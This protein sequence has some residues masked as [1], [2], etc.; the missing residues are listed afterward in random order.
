MSIPTS[1]AA[2]TSSMPLGASTSR[3][4]IVNFTVSLAGCVIRAFR[5]LRSAFRVEVRNAASAGLGPRGGRMLCLHRRAATG[6]R[7]GPRNAAR[8]TRHAERGRS[9]WLEGALA[10][11]NVLFVL[12][13]VLLDRRHDG[14][15]SEVAQGA[16]DF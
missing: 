8:G 7:R 6:A 13:G 1:L 12:G 11:L 14:A 9:P 3:S 2:S 15:G 16:Q 5:V 10:V 4:S